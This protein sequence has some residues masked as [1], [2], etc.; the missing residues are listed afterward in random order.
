M[1]QNMPHAVF[2]V[3]AGFMALTVILAFFTERKSP[4]RSGKTDA[5]L[6]PIAGG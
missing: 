3:S 4:A 2:L 6:S 1:D 5:A